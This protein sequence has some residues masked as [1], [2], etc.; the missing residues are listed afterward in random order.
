MPDLRL[1]RTC[2]QIYHEARSVLYDSNTFAFQSIGALTVYFGFTMPDQVHVPRS[3]DPD[4]LRSIHAMTRVEFCI[5]YLGIETSPGG[6]LT[7]SRLIRAALGCLTNLTSLELSLKI[8]GPTDL[9]REWK[10]DDSWFS[11]PPS[12]RKLIV[13]VH[14]SEDTEEKASFEGVK[15]E[16]AEEFV[17]RILKEE[18]FSDTLEPFWRC[19]ENAASGE[20]LTEGETR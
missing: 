2:R 1:L 14:D 4:K 3:T 6:I 15:L 7:M 8:H 12:L 19:E 11:K 10:I 17:R 20:P 16:A 9:Q 18:D 5:S 13:N